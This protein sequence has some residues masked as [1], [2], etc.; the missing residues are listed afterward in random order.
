MKISVIITI[1]NLE[2]YISKC[3]YSVLMQTYTNLEILLIN[4]GSTDL[5]DAICKDF[6]RKDL[7]IK[8]YYKENGGVSSARNLGIK[9]SSGDYIMFIDG[10]DYLYDSNA[11]ESLVNILNHNNCDILFFRM[12][13]FYYK[14]RSI[15]Y[16]SKLKNIKENM[17]Y[18]Y[19]ILY[20]LIHDSKLSISPCDKLIK[21][22]LLKEKQ[23]YFNEK[24][25]IYEDIDWS[26]KIYLDLSLKYSFTNNVVYVYR[27]QR[28]GSATYK[29]DSN[30][31]KSMF[32]VINY[33][34]LYIYKNNYIKNNYLNYLA[35][36]YAILLSFMNKNNCSTALKKEIFS[37]SNI[38]NYDDNYKVK[39]VNKVKTIFG[40]KATIYFLKV[41]TFLKNKGLY[42]IGENEK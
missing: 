10:D 5:S 32:L 2:K 3:I 16:D 8:Y 29:I 30:K 12:A 40:L 28:E 17:V 34:Y 9:H 13:S 42:R 37:I 14:K 20:K 1:Y 27:K 6:E 41:Y 36:Q 15:K 23:I 26:F 22:K 11:I 35:Y 4:D 38:L 25:K 39:K 7:R 21:T 31:L 33:W 24:L 19:K 18:S